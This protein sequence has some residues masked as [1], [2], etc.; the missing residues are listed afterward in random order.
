MC[1]NS[2]LIKKYLKK[3]SVVKSKK[4]FLRIKNKN[5]KKTCSYVT[6][7]FILDYFQP[8]Q[9]TFLVMQ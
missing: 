3:F 4:Q 5:N 1:G 6:Q 7:N 2:E 8:A 9:N